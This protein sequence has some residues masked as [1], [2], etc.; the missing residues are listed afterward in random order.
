MAQIN[1]NTDFVNE[2][3]LKALKT[4][5]M[6]WYDGNEKESLNCFYKDALEELLG[7]VIYGHWGEYTRAEMIINSWIRKAKKGE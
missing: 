5:I 6:K 4:N 2:E 7:L 3:E 1:L